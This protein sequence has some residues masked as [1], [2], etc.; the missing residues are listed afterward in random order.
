MNF[1]VVLDSESRNVLENP[2]LLRSQT[3]PIGP[4]LWTGMTTGG[5][6]GGQAGPSGPLV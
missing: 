1:D 6:M 3:G 4:F 2:C 5:P